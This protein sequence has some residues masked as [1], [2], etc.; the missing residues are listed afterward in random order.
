MKVPGPTILG[1]REGVRVIPAKTAVSREASIP[2]RDKVTTES[3]RRGKGVGCGACL[4]R[5]KQDPSDILQSDSKRVFASPQGQAGPSRAARIF[6]W[7]S[8][9]V[10]HHSE[11]VRLNMWIVDTIAGSVV[12]FAPEKKN[13]T[14]LPPQT[15]PKAAALW[16]VVVG[17][18]DAA[19]CRVKLVGNIVTH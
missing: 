3:W 6:A 4:W 14:Q 9:G 11:G 7:L 19:S 17:Q 18:P 10:F 16:R 13:S 15:L 8:R 12:L 5:P 2:H 1:S